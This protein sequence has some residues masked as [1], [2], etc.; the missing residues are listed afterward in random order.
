MELKDQINKA[1]GKDQFQLN[2]FDM[3]AS[4]MLKITK[5][6]KPF[7]E[8]WRKR[9]VDYFIENFIKEMADPIIDKMMKNC[10][11]E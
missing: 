6:E 4:M 11:T 10:D 8:Y 7:R 3:M 1:L 2:A 9:L 5:D